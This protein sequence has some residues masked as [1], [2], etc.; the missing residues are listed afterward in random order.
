[1][2][3][4]FFKLFKMVVN[5]CSKLE[6]RSVIKFLVAEKCK[7]CES[8]WRMYNVNR[9]A[10]FSQKKSLQWSKYGFVIIMSLNQKDNPWSWNKVTLK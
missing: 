3:F 9:E 6:Q 4:F 5:Q 2:F 8:Y 10:Y 7:P 1:M